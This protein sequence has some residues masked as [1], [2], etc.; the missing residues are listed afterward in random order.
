MMSYNDSLFFMVMIWIKAAQ[1]LLIS[2]TSLMAMHN[3][4]FATRNA[5]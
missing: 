2:R 5:A 1:G 3:A 4:P